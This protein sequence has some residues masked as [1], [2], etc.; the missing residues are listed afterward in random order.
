MG[1]MESKHPHAAPGAARRG[2]PPT[3]L[4][5][6]IIAYR[7]LVRYREILAWAA[8][9]IYHLDAGLAIDPDIM[10]DIVEIDRFLNQLCDSL[11]HGIDHRY[12]PYLWAFAL[13][14]VPWEED[15]S[16]A[17]KTRW[18]DSFHRKVRYRP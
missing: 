10:E 16:A 1:A 9:R 5:S 6:D 14:P 2:D 11:G 15:Q 8:H 12:C 3:G 18:L 7:Q 17:Q 4:A 13:G